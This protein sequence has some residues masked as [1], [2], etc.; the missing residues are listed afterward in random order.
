MIHGTSFSKLLA[1][2]LKNYR[3][4]LKSDDFKQNLS[5][6]EHNKYQ[7]EL[8][9]LFKEFENRINDKFEFAALKIMVPQL[10]K[11][12][13]FMNENILRDQL[14]AKVLSITP[15][16]KG[17]KGFI[18]IFAILQMPDDRK[19]EIQFLTYPRYK[20]SK[21]GNF[22]HSRMCNKQLDISHFFELKDEYKNSKNYKNTLKNAIHVLDDTTIAEKNR[23]LATPVDLLTPEQRRLRKEIEFAENNLQVKEL[24]TDEH[25]L[26]QR[27]K[28][29][30]YESKKVTQQYTLEKYLPIFAQYHSPRLIAVSSPHSRTNKNTAFVNIKTLFDNFREV[31]LKTDETTCLADMLLKQLKKIQEGDPYITLHQSNMKQILQ[32]YGIPEN[33]IDDLIQQMS[34]DSRTIRM[35]YTNSVSDIKER[36]EDKNAGR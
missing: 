26:V 24:F 34:N 18:A 28:D 5:Y 19:I 35:S 1:S 22:A 21:V 11:D 12:K 30:S 27:K 31:L 10:L 33:K 13:N 4:H 23:L 16:I 6:E 2:S 7:D 32:D 25:I 36:V 20:D 8:Q 15:K 29:G 17:R 3:S 9:S 14:D